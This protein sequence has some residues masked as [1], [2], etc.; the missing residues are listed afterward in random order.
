MYKIQDANRLGSRRANVSVFLSDMQA[1][2][3][4]S[5][6]QLIRFWESRNLRRNGDLKG[7]VMILLNSQFLSSVLTLMDFK[8]TENGCEI[9]YLGHGVEADDVQLKPLL[10]TLCV[11][12]SLDAAKELAFLH[13]NTVKVIYRD[14]KA[15]KILLEP[16]LSKGETSYG[17]RSVMGTIGYE[18]L[19]LGCS[20]ILEK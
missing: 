8:V 2:R 12:V 6:V 10:W 18:A 17:I 16:E 13:G 3:S 9:N 1:D 15:S 7:V 11:N 19:K 20:Q 14:I 4:S 5:T